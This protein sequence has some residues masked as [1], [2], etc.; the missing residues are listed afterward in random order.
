MQQLLADLKALEA[1]LEENAFVTGDIHIGAEQEMFLIDASCQPA[2]VGP[3]ILARSQEPRLTRELA[4]F[5]L[6]LNLDPLPFAA[7]C[8]AR[9][10]EDLNSL[11][12]K[13]RKVAALEGAQVFLVG[14]LPTLD[15]GDL[16]LDNMTPSARYYALNEAVTRLRGKD[17]DLHLKGPDELRLRHDNVMLE[18]CNTSFQLHLQVD[19]GD[20]ARLHNVAQAATAPVLAAAVFSPLLFGRRLWQETRIALFSQSIDTR[21]GS[22]RRREPARVSFG[23]RWLDSSI[24]EVFRQDIA[25]FRLLLATEEWHDPAAAMA[26]GEVPTLDALR[27]HNGTVYHWNRACYGHAKDRPHLRIENRVLPAGPTV[28]DE[29][30][31]AAFWFGLI[32]GLDETHQDITR[33]LSFDAARANFLAASRLGLGA[34]L[35][36]LDGSIHSAPDLIRHEL[37]PLARVGLASRGLP[38]EEIER[39]LQVIDGRVQT[40]QSGS[41]WMLDSLAAQ[42][43]GLRDAQ[44]MARLTATALQL[45][46]KGE[47]VHQWPLAEA[48]PNEAP[49]QVFHRVRHLMT[50]DLF[51]VSQEE[52]IDLVA[53]MMDWKHIRHV[54]VEDNRHRLV[55]LI[56]HRTLLRHMAGQTEDRH[57][58]IAV[59]EIMQRK[60]ITIA[61]DATTLEAMALMSQHRI[62][63]LPVVEKDRL[64]GILSERDL[65]PLARDLLQRFLSESDASATE[66]AVATSQEQAKD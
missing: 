41:Q 28:I 1:L 47:P 20:F 8:L 48:A 11:L 32:C 14:I 65:M 52:V 25:R 13:V 29:V 53:S 60:V 27:L 22:H 59:H 42:P 6:E 61:P 37:L 18:A 16:G 3:E 26:R 50:T 43:D 5:N 15:K 12:A 30:A 57:T 49:R 9:L 2:P 51:T 46:Q 56:T 44:R 40:R 10:E 35:H 63:C 54:P 38:S 23:E 66:D 4:R 24:S 31:N 19:P 7:G 39:Y 45:Q 36:W 62:A 33:H 17:F 55:G 64:V 58:P 34:N 21:R